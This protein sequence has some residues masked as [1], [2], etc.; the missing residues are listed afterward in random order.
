ME[1][2]VLGLHWRNRVRPLQE[3]S[4]HVG[5]LQKP[6]IPF[7]NFHMV[8][9]Y[10]LYTPQVNPMGDSLPGAGPKAGLTRC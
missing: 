5:T 10:R 3:G 4:Y 1:G 8:L 9:T 2:L 7:N 6:F